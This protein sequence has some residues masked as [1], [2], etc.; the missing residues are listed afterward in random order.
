M[1]KYKNLYNNIS[2]VVVRH[3]ESD[4]N[5][6]GI[7]SDKNVD[8][9]LTSRGIQQARNTAELLQNEHFD[10]IVTS[11]RQ[12]ARLTATIINEYHRAKIIE[13]ENLIERDFGVISG[14]SQNEAKIKMVNEGFT[15]INIPES[16][17][18]EEID[19]RVLKF[20]NFIEKYHADSVVLVSTH[21]DVVKSFHRLLNG[22]SIEKSTLIDVNNSEPHCFS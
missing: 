1:K 9:K 16:E 13:C 14:V 21:A 8:H 7:I 12:R 2:F 20:L 15:W 19:S 6:R 17:K 11:T 3:G 4:A 18:A 5:R 22:E 10:V